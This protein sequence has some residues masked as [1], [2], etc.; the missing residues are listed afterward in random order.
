MDR[1]PACELA[2]EQM[3]EWQQAASGVP[4]AVLEAAESVFDGWYANGE[5]I[6]W[7]DFIDRVEQMSGADLGTDMLS[8]TIKGIKVHVRKYRK[9]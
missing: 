5:R 7:H 2:D 6:D 3:N 1:R 9:L 4:S 8:P